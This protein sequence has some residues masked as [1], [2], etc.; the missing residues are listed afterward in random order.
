MPAS[1]TSK[2][3]G[4]LRKVCRQRV[5]RKMWEQ[6]RHSHVDRLQGGNDSDAAKQVEMQFK[7][8]HISCDQCDIQ[9]LLMVLHLVVSRGPSAVTTSSRA[10]FMQPY[11]IKTVPDSLA[12]TIYQKP[13]IILLTH[14]NSFRHNWWDFP[15]VMVLKNSGVTAFCVTKATKHT[16]MFLN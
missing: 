16:V 4:L 8:F 9:E 15:S 1:Q 2:S 12:G 11:G 13:Q 5:C 6:V 3:W 7:I 10:I 14:I